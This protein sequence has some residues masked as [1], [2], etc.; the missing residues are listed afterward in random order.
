MVKI[1]SLTTG[2]QSVVIAPHAS[3]HHAEGTDPISA[4]AIGARPIG[5]YIDWG[6]IGDPPDFAAIY[7]AIA[8]PIHWGEILDPPATYPPTT[9]GNSHRLG[10]ADYSELLYS[11]TNYDFNN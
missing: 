1:I 3:T 8:D 2:E 11:L 5:V 10:G 4:K 6:E 9:H 7:R